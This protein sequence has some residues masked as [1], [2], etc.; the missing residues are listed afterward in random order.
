MCTYHIVMAMHHAC[1]DSDGSGSKSGVE[2]S[3]RGCEMVVEDSNSTLTV[4]ECNH[5]THFAIL[6]SP[7]LNVRSPPQTLALSRAVTA[8]AGYCCRYQEAMQLLFK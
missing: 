7:G 4:C 6:L 5:L 8:C 1:V 3:D 2:L